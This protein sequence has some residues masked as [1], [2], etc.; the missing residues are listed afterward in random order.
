MEQPNDSVSSIR[1]GV[2][3]CLLGEPV[4]YDGSHKA[5]PFIIETLGRYFSWVPVCPEVEMGLGTPRETLRLVGDAAAPNLIATVSGRHHTAA[6]QHFAAK[7]LPEL[8][9]LGLHG[10]ILKKNS[11]SCGLT[12]VPVYDSS[13]RPRGSGRGLFAQAL[14]A[15]LPLLPVEEEGRLQD[16]RRREHFVER[17]FACRRWHEFLAAHPAPADLV[18]FHRRHEL[19]LLAHSRPHYQAL[20]R[21]VAGC[22]EGLSE[23]FLKAYGDLFMLAFKVRTSRKKHADALSRVQG[24]LKRRL[25]KPEKAALAGCIDDY[26]QGLGPLTTPL[27]LLRDHLRRV[28][29]PYLEAQTYLNPYPAD[30]MRLLHA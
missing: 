9:R 8:V 27:D 30:L 12:G 17:V 20:G 14:A 22:G 4:R 11:P 5:D 15:R 23:E 3:A 25:G 24:C 29:C 28:G 26:R 10:Y 16:P 21:T 6:M 19:S 7:R 18:Q 13:G 2:S 1:I